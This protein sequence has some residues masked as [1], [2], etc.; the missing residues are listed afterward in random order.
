MD[1]ALF[2]LLIVALAAAGGFAVG[3]SVRRR[4]TAA[5]RYGGACLLCPAGTWHEDR[6]D[7]P[8]WAAF[9]KSHRR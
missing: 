8:K 3:W 5:F 7:C 9:E 4:A 1:P 6:D 2:L